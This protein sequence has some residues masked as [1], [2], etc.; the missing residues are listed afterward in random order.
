MNKIN[1]KSKEDLLQLPEAI[2]N[3]VKNTLKAFNEVSVIFEYG[4]Y[5]ASTG[6]C[7]KAKYADDYKVFGTFYVDDIYTLDERT[8]NYMESFHDYPI[9]YKGKR[10]YIELKARFN[11]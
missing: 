4:E 1:A 2:Q 6:H 7:L 11:R 8:E 10:D 9:W 3:K 5:T